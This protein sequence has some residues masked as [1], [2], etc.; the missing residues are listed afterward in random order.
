MKITALEHVP[1]SGVR[2][3]ARRMVDEAER[4]QGFAVVQAAKQVNEMTR[5]ARREPPVTVADHTPVAVSAAGVKRLSD[6]EKAKLVADGIGAAFQAYNPTY[7]TAFKG[8]MLVG[9]GVDVMERAVQGTED[10]RSLFADAVIAAGKAVEFGLSLWPD[11]RRYVPLASLCTVLLRLSKD[12]FVRAQVELDPNDERDA[13]A[14]TA[15]ADLSTLTI[16]SPAEASARGGV[17]G[18][19]GS[20]DDDD[21]VGAAR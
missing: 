6:V 7:G 1:A 3:A 12:W 14:A 8:F 11:G 5:R 15:L 4:E 17:A 18:V 20:M 2:R 21:P 9:E 10:P 19:V 13:A 16:V